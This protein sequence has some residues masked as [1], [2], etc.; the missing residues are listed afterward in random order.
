MIYETLPAQVGF[1]LMVLVC[2]AA[3]WKGDRLHRLVA[4]L[5]AAAWVA[6]GLVHDSENLV[7]PQWGIFAV[8]FAL[9]VIGS[10]V[11]IRSRPWWVLAWAAVLWLQL[12]THLAML[13]DDRV[14]VWAYVTGMAIW[15]RLQ[16]VLLAYGTWTCWRGKGDWRGI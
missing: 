15:G 6:S 14:L 7:S 2:A 8:D 4:V 12:M 9:A 16:L 11:A 13:F 1:G 5:I 3:L 10:V